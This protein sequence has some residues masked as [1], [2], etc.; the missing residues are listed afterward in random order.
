MT[1]NYEYSCTN[2]DDLPLPVKMQSPSKLKTFSPILIAFFDSALNFEHLEKKKNQ[3]QSSHISEVIDS[4]G[5]A[6]LNA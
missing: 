6:Y 5:L 3:G 4:Q 1:A 2:A